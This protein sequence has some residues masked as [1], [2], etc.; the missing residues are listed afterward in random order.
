MS[1]PF[2]RLRAGALPGRVAT[3]AAV[4][5]LA[6][7]LGAVAVPPA[8]AVEGEQARAVLRLADGKRAG[9]VVFLGTGST[10]TRVE[11]SVQFPRFTRTV[12]RSEVPGFHGLHVHA[13]SD[14]ANGEGCVADPA[15]PRPTW[16]VSA[17]GHLREGLEEHGAHVG[18]LPPLLLTEGGRGYTVTL[19]DRFDVADVVGRAVILHLLRD[20][21]GHVPTGTEPTQYTANS[22][23]A[24]ELTAATGN[25]GPRLACGVV[26]AR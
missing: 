10:V 14:P 3:L 17:D 22:R 1:P 23:A 19:T 13:N 8:S 25:A 18:D 12:Q 20:N 26:T 2:G 11:V 16:F 7:G 21:L 6:L 15:Q 4:G 24:T 5:A 9:R